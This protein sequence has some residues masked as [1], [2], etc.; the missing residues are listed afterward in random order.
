MFYRVYK[1]TYCGRDFG[2]SDGA[3]IHFSGEC[4]H[5]YKPLFINGHEALK[6]SFNSLF[7]NFLGTALSIFILKQYQPHSQL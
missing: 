5:C 6:H 7:W 3:M 2:D 4:P 1:C